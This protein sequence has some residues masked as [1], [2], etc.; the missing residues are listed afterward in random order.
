M[1]PVD[2]AGLAAVLVWLA[3][4]AEGPLFLES[5][6]RQH[7]LAGA[8]PRSVH[9]WRGRGGVIGL[10]T[11]GVLTPQ[12]ALAGD[13]DWRAA[14]AAL[15]GRV[16]GRMIGDA[17]QVRRAQTALGL[18]GAPARLDREEPAFVLT[19]SD[20]VMPDTAGLSLRPT[21]DADLPLLIRWNTDYRVEILGDDSLSAEATARANVALYHAEASHRLLW[22]GDRPVALT[23]FNARVPGQVQV[24]GVYTPPDLRC[25]GYARAAV[26]LHLAEARTQ[27]VTR[28][29]LFAASDP[30]ARAYTAIGFR[31]AGQVALVIPA[32]PQMVAS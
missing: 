9:L 31:P 19:L 27:D 11:G 20:L 21:R 17:G 3:R 32:E 7:G 13:A 23:G 29:F 2:A 15:A 5:N 6:L 25:R 26:A 28:A 16:I 12:M 10:T 24:G 4:F 22:R 18:S 14:R 1:Q 8:D 30:A